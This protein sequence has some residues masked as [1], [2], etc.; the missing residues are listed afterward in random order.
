[1]GSAYIQ[2]MV[3]P[4][5]FMKR[6]CTSRRALRL[7]ALATFTRTVCPRRL[8]TSLARAKMRIL[9]SSSRSKPSGGER[10]ADIHL[11]RHQQRDGG[12]RTAGRDRLGLQAQLPDQSEHHAVGGRAVGRIGH[13]VGAG[14]VLDGLEGRVPPSRSR[15]RRCRWRYPTRCGSARPW[16]RRRA[17]RACRRRSRYRRCRRSPPAGFRRCLACTA[18]RPRCH[19]AHRRRC[20][21]RARPARNPNCRTARPPASIC[22]R[23]APDRR[24]ISTDATRR[25]RQ[26][27]KSGIRS[28][29]CSLRSRPSRPITA[30][31]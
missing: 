22:R 16:R 31:S 23:R 12:G 21:C 8:G 20:G 7:S 6:T 24:A 25:K 27:P 3:S 30:R 28:S 1:M 29:E 5:A 10:P 9:P 2:S 19:A 13:G 17:R 26:R 11:S 15:S 4:N 18:P 14:R